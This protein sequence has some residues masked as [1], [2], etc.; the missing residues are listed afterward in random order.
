V[1]LQGPGT[2]L[3]TTQL[4]FPGESLNEQDGLFS[5]SLLMRVEESP[6]GSLRAMFDFVLKDSEA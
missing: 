3:L 1:K 4:Y 5:E 6:D 2:S